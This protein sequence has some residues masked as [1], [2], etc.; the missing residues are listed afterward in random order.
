MI[1]SRAAHGAG[2]AVAAPD[3]PWRGLYRAGAIAA[4]L[5]V[6][7]IIIPIVLLN[8]APVPPLIGGAAIL[9]YIAAHKLVY[10]IELVSFVGLSLPA[11]I[12][13]LALYVALRDHDPSSAAL[14]A[15][16]GIASVGR[17]LPYRWIPR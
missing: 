12:V 11:M 8:V 13:F 1:A 2:E 17:G 14:G 10:L 16:F 6:L 5:Y 9:D 15:K 7:L 3:R 4:A